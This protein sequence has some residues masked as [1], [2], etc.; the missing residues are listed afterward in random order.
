MTDSSDERQTDEPE[1][2]TVEAEDTRPADAETEPAVALDPLPEDVGE[3]LFYEPGGSWW[4]VVIGPALLAL[5][6]WL[7]IAGKGRIHW[8]VLTIFGVVLIGFS[9][10]QVKAARRHVSVRLTE[11]TLQQGTRTIA[12]SDIVTVYPENRGGD[13]QD[14]ESAPALGELHAVP[15]RRKGVGVKLKNGK[16]AQAWARDV[17][18]F[19][20]ELTDAH[21]AVKLGLPPKGTKSPGE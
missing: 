11:Q 1:V 2:D 16:L 3:T 15:R 4:V 18:R 6:L 20:S 10:L 5:T 7:E 19:R 13:F 14:W 17:D 8:E 12:L 9:I 21:L